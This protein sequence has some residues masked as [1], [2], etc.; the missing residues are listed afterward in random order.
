MHANRILRAGAAREQELVL[1]YLL[2]RL[3]EG[4][5]ARRG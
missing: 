4:L 2:D 5:L 3:Y 1:H